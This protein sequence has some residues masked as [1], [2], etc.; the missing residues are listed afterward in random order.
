M[1]IL[2][3]ILSGGVGSRLWPLSRSSFPKQYLKLDDYSNNTLLQETFLRLDGI[4]KLKNP[5]IICN[6]E[7]RFIAAE[8]MRQ[9]K[10]Q[11]KE[12]ILEPFGKNTAAAIALAALIAVENKNDPILLVLSADH[13]ISNKVSFREAIEEGV[14]FAQKGRL[15][16]FGI[17]PSSPETGYGYIESELEISTQ[18]RSS[19]I[20]RFIEKPNR[21]IAEKFLNDKTFTWNSGIFLFKASTILSELMKFEPKIIDTCKKSLIDNV[22]DLNFRRINHKFFELCPSKPIDIAVMEKT[23]LGTVVKLDAGWDDLGSWK[24]VWDN[25]K[26]DE[27]KNST[28]GRTFIKNVKNSYLRSENRLIVGLGLENIC[29]IE[30]DDS[31]LIANKESIES[32]K[33]LVVDLDK[34]NFEEIKINK[35]VHRPWGHFTSL[36]KGENWQVKRLQVN[37]Y[38][39]LSLQKHNFRAENWVIVKGTA[40]VEIDEKISFLNPNESTYIPIGSIH[41]LSNTQETPLEIIEVQ[42]GTYLGEDDIIRFED[43]YKRKNL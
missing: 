15:V 29:V 25:S 18:V 2:P 40:T 3:I 17:Q 10:V 34:N 6:E 13:K 19:N 37:P 30:T 5:I 16:T 11:P 41:R 27:N 31:V 32:M 7:Q 1:D 22:I 28:K 9:I 23:T 33:E 38:E 26:K 36:I 24:S 21:D 20:K 14:S 4:K 35:K 12:I 8:Q 43:K 42:I 39:G